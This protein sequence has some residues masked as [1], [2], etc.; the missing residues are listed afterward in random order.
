M[1]I[2]RPCIY[3]SYSS[4]APSTVYSSLFHYFKLVKPAADSGS[5]R[6]LI[7]DLVKTHSWF[8]FVQ[9]CFVHSQKWIYRL[10]KL[11][12]LT[13]EYVLVKWD[14]WEVIAAT[15]E[16]V[17]YLYLVST[18]QQHSE[19]KSDKTLT[20]LTW[21]E[22]V[23]KH[24]SQSCDLL[25]MLVNREYLV[26]HILTV[27]SEVISSRCFFNS[28]SVDDSKLSCEQISYEIQTN[29]TFLLSLKLSI[30]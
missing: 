27:H 1:S 29:V 14:K 3:S 8:I 19:T 2:S 6:W 9:I 5:R 25:Y 21:W 24:S 17:K 26:S 11:S 12:D 22:D 10:W 16:I 4:P 28:T 15:Q 13:H 23:E 30:F 20:D 7:L 18:L